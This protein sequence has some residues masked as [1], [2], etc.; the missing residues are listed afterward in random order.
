MCKTQGCYAQHYVL[1]LEMN[2]GLISDETAQLIV[3][4]SLGAPHCNTSE[5]DKK[6]LNETSVG[7]RQTAYTH[8]S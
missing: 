1:H 6:M 8:K 4:N 5:T 7:S 3:D 2:K